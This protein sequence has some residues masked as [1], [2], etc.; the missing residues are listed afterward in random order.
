MQTVT[1]LNCGGVCKSWG[2]LRI[3]LRTL[4]NV[5]KSIPEFMK[6][7][8]EYHKTFLWERKGKTRISQP[9]VH[10]GQ[11]PS[12]YRQNSLYTH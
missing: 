10:L 12:P 5:E 6:G 8:A 4:W 9:E 3:H 7:R 1:S 11:F 2:A